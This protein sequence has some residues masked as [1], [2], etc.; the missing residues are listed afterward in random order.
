MGSAD[1]KVTQRNVDV[2]ERMVMVVPSSVNQVS[3]DER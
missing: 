2:Q 3:G 1:A